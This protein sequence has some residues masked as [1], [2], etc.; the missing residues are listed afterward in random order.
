MLPDGYGD[1]LFDEF[2]TLLAHTTYDHLNQPKP[3]T[4]SQI[5]SESK[6]QLE[7]I[8]SQINKLRNECHLSV[9]ELADKI[10]IDPRSVKRHLAGT[11]QPYP[12]YLR[13]YQ[14]V[15]SNLLN[16]PISIH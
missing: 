1:E 4:K 13:A 14:T 15:F 3:K 16:R 7:S 10:G 2:Y 8:S 6:P 12:Q 11:T 5:A 9:E